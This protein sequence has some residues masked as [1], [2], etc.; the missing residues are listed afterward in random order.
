MLA[1]SNHSAPTVSTD[2]AKLEKYLR[3][4][5]EFLAMHHPQTQFASEARTKK[6]RLKEIESPRAERRTAI[7]RPTKR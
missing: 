4:A 7:L 6:P 2:T 1:E 3:A 5:S